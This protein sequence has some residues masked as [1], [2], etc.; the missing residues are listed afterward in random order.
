VLVSLN[1]PNIAAIHGLEEHA[2]TTALVMELVEGENLAER[3]AR[4]PNRR[5]A[6][7]RSQTLFEFQTY[8]I[9]PHGN[10]FS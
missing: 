7:H 10:Q 5:G 6:R 3:L 4:G 1:H 9:L 8:V 2:D